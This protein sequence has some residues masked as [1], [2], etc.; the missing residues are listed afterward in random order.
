MFN[1]YNSLHHVLLTCMLNSNLC[2]VQVRCLK[3][4]IFFLKLVG[5]L[6]GFRSLYSYWLGRGSRW[7]FIN[8]QY[9]SINHVLLI[10]CTSNS[11]SVSSLYEVPETSLSIFSEPGQQSGTLKFKAR[12][13]KLYLK[14]NIVRPV[15]DGFIFHK[16]QR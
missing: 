4:S 10:T 16:K 3:L 15:G 9:N 1:K 2:Q 12:C 7:S 8:K 14:F 6:L 11:K 5:K 13:T